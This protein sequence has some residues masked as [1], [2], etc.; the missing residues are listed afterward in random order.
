MTYHETP[1]FSQHR[2]IA[3]LPLGVYML[4]L[5][6]FQRGVVAYLE[7]LESDVRTWNRSGLPPGVLTQDSRPA[8]LARQPDSVLWLDRWT[9]IKYHLGRCSSWVSPPSLRHIQ[10]PAFPDSW[11][12]AQ[13]SGLVLSY[14]RDDD[15]P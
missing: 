4:P 5:P 15:Q 1:E 2:P 12:V 7:W 14:Q 6:L 10:R 11:R 13:L 9:R 8:P 3:G